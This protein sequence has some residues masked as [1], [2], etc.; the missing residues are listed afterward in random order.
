MKKV[1]IDEW[2]KMSE[3]ERGENY[4]YLTDHEKFKVRTLYTIPKGKDTGYQEVSDEE[5]IRVRKEW[6][7]LLVELGEMTREEADELMAD[8]LLELQK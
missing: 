3:K 8:L 5:R 4:R 1:T 2:L 7:E 6:T